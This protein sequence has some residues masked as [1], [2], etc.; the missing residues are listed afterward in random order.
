M[1]QSFLLSLLFL[2]C[3]LQACLQPPDYSDV[4]EI[5]YVG[6]DK[7]FVKQG[8]SER[9]NG[10]IVSLSDTLTITIA[11]TDGDGDIGADLDSLGNVDFLNNV[12]F[13]DNRTNQ[14]SKISVPFIPALGL[15]NGI[16]GQI[17]FEIYTAL[18][19]M[20]CIYDDKNGQ[21]PCTSSTRY[22]TD[23]MT[24]TIY[25]VDQAGN[26][27]NRIETEPIILLCD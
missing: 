15:G 19:G 10:Q 20:C 21:D 13:I 16:S 17:S 26:E 9:I 6:M 22:P 3:G 12:V 2:L 7:M 1:K 23:T 14:D 24:Y 18:G 8:S 4:P 5:A 27:S 11:Y 25:I